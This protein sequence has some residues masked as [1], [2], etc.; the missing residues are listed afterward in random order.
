MDDPLVHWSLRGP[1]SSPDTC[2][3]QTRE[4]D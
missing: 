4:T 2:S 1:A 3:S